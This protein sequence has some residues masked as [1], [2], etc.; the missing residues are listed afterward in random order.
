MVYISITGDEVA[1]GRGVAAPA[2]YTIQRILYTKWFRGF[3]SLGN[4]GFGVCGFWGIIIMISEV[5]R[6]ILENYVPFIGSVPKFR[7]LTFVLDTYLTP[8]SY[9]QPFT[10]SFG[11]I[12]RVVGHIRRVVGDLRRGF[13]YVL[14]FGGLP[15]PRKFNKHG[16]NKF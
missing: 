9:L 2:M 3:W 14:P 11:H 16:K 10:Y 5:Y 8:D 1:Q 15:A 4:R 13:G 12:R 6:R 7:I